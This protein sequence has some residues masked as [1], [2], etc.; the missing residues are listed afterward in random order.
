MMKK[1]WL[2]P[3]ELASE[4][5]L[6][7][8]TVN[9]WIK[10]E[11]WTTLPRPGIQG[12]KARLIHVDDRVEKFI[13]STHSLHEPAAMYRVPADSLTALLVN[14][15]PQMSQAEQEQL[16]A[17]ILRIGIKGM[18]QRLDITEE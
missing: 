1:E 5:G 8:Q 2:T 13:H 14:A 12:G 3:E 17:L 11:N 16:S 15:V 9:K 6:S 10:R 4:T 18:L 7:R